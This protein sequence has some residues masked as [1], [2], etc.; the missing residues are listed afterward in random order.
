M[1]INTETDSFINKFNRGDFKYDIISSAD[2]DDYA[3]AVQQVLDGT[4][5]I[6]TKMRPKF[7]ENALKGLLKCVPIQKRIRPISSS[8]D[9]KIKLAFKFAGEHDVRTYV[10]AVM[11]TPES[12]TAT[13]GQRLFSISCDTE[14]EEKT[15]IN[16]SMK[17]LP[18]ESYP[19]WKRLI[20]DTGEMN[21]VL[22][23]TIK[24]SEFIRGALRAY[25]LTDSSIETIKLMLPSTSSILPIESK[26]EMCFNITYLMSMLE[27]F[28]KLRVP[29]FRMYFKNNMHSAM[30]TSIK[31][32]I[33]HLLMTVQMMSIKKTCLF[34]VDMSEFI[35]DFAV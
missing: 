26:I 30:M 21:H 19:E 2:H 24:F 33:I 8:I 16:R 12:I 14:Y 29:L 23:N 13:D 11:I 18:A 15:L 34:N 28:E 35:D 9:D 22:I 32:D 20:P 27:A 1:I 5:K 17:K 31:G 3:A 6:S 25:K 7:S 10:N 4:V